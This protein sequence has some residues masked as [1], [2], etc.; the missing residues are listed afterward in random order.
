MIKGGDALNVCF[1]TVA[2]M[3]LCDI[4]NLAYAVFLPEDLRVMVETNGRVELGKEEAKSLMR[5]K[6]VH[7]IVLVLVVPCAVAIGGSGNAVGWFIGMVLP[8]IAWWIAGVVAAVVG[9]ADAS[10]ALKEAGKTTGRWM[11]GMIG[12]VVLIVASVLI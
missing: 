12:M 5:S 2:V 9:A 3:F 8:L 4:D 7:V 11:F 10:E 1:N 6:V